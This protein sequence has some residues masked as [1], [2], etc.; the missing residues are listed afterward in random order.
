MGR[1]YFGKK[2]PKRKKKDFSRRWNFIRWELSQDPKKQALAE[3]LA[4]EEHLCILESGSVDPD[5]TYCSAGG[6]LDQDRLYLVHLLGYLDCLDPIPEVF[7]MRDGGWR[8]GGRQRLATLLG[9]TL[10]FYRL[11]GSETFE[12]YDVVEPKAPA[13]QRTA[14]EVG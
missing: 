13:D 6:P 4:A 9:K 5:W 1:G 2:S 8:D 12:Q 7:F 10:Y 3:R 14:G 11:T